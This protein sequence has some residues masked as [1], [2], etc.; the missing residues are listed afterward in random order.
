MTQFFFE[1]K[2]PCFWST[3]GPFSNFWGGKQ[4]FP[5]NHTTSYEFLA[6]CQNLEKSGN[7]IPRKHPDT[8]K[9]GWKDRK[10][11]RKLDRPYFIGLFRLLPGVQQRDYFVFR[12]FVSM[13]KL[14]AAEISPPTCFPGISALTHNIIPPLWQFWPTLN[15]SL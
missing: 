11:G 7:I 3:F 9:A 6:P 4:F 14:P 13:C 12:K 5:E 10:K 8:Q 2:K 15:R 1:F